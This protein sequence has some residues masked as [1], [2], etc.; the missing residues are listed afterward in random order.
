MKKLSANE[1]QEMIN[2]RLKYGA[3]QIIQSN[4]LCKTC[5][6]YLN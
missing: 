4:L 3:A 6:I 5:I 2:R 1:K